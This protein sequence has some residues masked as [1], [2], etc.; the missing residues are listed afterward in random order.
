MCIRDSWSLG[1]EPARA[2]SDS[3]WIAP[4][5]AQLLEDPYDAVRFIAYRS[6]RK[7][8]GFGDFQY[9]YVASPQRRAQADL[10]AL[11]IW[12]RS[13][14]KNRS[15]GGSAVLFDAQGNLHQKIFDRLVSQRNDYPLGLAE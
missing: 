2:V 12:R 1:W 5:L 4:Y 6:L 15:V 10:N 14:Q 3:G 8:P 9:D 13:G 11:E 7:L